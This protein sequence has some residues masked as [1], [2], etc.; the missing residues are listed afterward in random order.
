MAY[1]VICHVFTVVC[2]I[3]SKCRTEANNNVVIGISVKDIHS[4][5]GPTT[6]S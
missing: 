5:D 1:Y 6:A 2:Q 4:C 3:G